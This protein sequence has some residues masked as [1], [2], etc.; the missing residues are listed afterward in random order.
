MGWLI[1]TIIFVVLAATFFRMVT[2]FEGFYWSKVTL[3]IDEDVEKVERIYKRVFEKGDVVMDAAN[4]V[5][6]LDM[7]KY[8]GRGIQVY[9]KDGRPAINFKPL[10]LWKPSPQR[11]YGET[12]EGEKIE[13]KR[14]EIEFI[15]GY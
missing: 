6:E 4:K 14:D 7:E 2:W 10:K 3:Y 1:E 9:F 11:W 8:L 5:V 15:K 12:D 13:I